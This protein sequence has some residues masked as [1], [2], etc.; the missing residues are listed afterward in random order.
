MFELIIAG[1]VFMGIVAI[2]IRIGNLFF[3]HIAKNE[4]LKIYGIS[5]VTNE[6]A[7]K[8][9]RTKGSVHDMY[10]SLMAIRDRQS[11]KF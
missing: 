10:K 5:D 4:L 9:G 8:I 7:D 3:R 1:I 6:E 2:I 11:K